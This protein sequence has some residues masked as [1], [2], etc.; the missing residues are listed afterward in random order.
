M[1][2]GVVG[3]VGANARGCLGSTPRACGPRRRKGIAT[4]F[5]FHFYFFN[6]Q[7]YLD[8]FEYLTNPLGMCNPPIPYIP[9]YYKKESHGS[10]LKMLAR[11]FK[12]RIS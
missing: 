1:K 6:K 12:L 5:L 7:E 3:V 8:L 10:G 9:G 2:M 4:F 11:G